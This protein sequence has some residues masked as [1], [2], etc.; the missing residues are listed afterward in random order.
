[1]QLVVSAFYG[2]KLSVSCSY[3]IAASAKIFFKPPQTCQETMVSRF[4]QEALCESARSN[5]V[6]LQVGIITENRATG[7]REGV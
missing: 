5:P 4:L 7:R 3:L 6:A 2:A 1:M